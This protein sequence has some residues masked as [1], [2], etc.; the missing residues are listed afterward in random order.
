MPGVVT[1]HP[2]NASRW[3]HTWGFHKI[4]IMW[5][6]LM[7]RLAGEGNDWVQRKDIA[8]ARDG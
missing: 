5:N 2:V 4:G 1:V 7:A 3:K 8:P 6:T